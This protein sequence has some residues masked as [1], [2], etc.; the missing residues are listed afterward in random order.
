MPRAVG[1]VTVGERMLDGCEF[2]H[3]VVQLGS[4]GKL[5]LLIDCENIHRRCGLRAPGRVVSLLGIREQIQKH[6]RWTVVEGEK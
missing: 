3:R 2:R 4:A 6:L 1:T 5:S